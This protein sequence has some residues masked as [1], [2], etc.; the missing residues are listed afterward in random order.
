MDNSFAREAVAPPLRILSSQA[1]VRAVLEPA[2]IAT[3]VPAASSRIAEEIRATPELTEGDVSSPEDSP[4]AGAPI[5]SF[6]P[7]DYDV[8][9]EKLPAHAGP[10]AKAGLPPLDTWDDVCKEMKFLCE[11]LGVAVPAF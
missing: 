11:Q 6:S 5:L 3:P 7:E 4:F 9:L 1:A 2:V 10:P 8:F